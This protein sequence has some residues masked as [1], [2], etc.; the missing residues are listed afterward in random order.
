MIYIFLKVISAS[1]I[2]VLCCN[3][4]IRILIVFTFPTN[5]G[6]HHLRQPKQQPLPNVQLA[7]VATRQLLGI[8]SRITA[9][10][11]TD[12]YRNL[13][14]SSR[15]RNMSNLSADQY[16]L[17]SPQSS[18]NGGGGGLL[19]PVSSCSSSADVGDEPSDVASSGDAMSLSTIAEQQR[20]KIIAKS[21]SPSLVAG[22][23]RDFCSNVGGFRPE[24]RIRADDQS[25]RN[26]RVKRRPQ[27]RLVE[28]TIK[29]PRAL[30]GPAAA[31]LAATSNG[32]G[33]GRGVAD[34]DDGSSASKR[35]AGCGA[36][37]PIPCG[38]QTTTTMN[39]SASASTSTTTTTTESRAPNGRTPPPTSQ[40]PSS[41]QP[42]VGSHNGLEAQLI[43]A[44]H[45]SG[46]QMTGN[47]PSYEDSLGDHFSEPGSGM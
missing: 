12:N 5:L 43:Q 14:S 35:L 38:S 31:G 22:R 23:P 45:P 29:R 3:L 34:S 36:A 8:G 15:L 13:P 7:S 21:R 33:G 46:V 1:Q 42:N 18:V 26:P 47:T 17:L 30:D 4:Y 19:S 16:M 2:V 37:E 41:V 10:E 27:R 40:L 25:L 28:T 11:K 44:T 9:E 32:C 39:S 6:H 24:S 20:A